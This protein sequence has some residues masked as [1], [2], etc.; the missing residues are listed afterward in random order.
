MPSGSVVEDLRRGGA[1][2]RE[3]SGAARLVA[4]GVPGWGAGALAGLAA[5]AAVP[6]AAPDRQQHA[7]S[8]FAGLPGSELG[9]AGSG[10]V[11]EVPVVGH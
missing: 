6:T 1:A 11:G 3:V 4:W 7:V 2:G 8:G 10:P 9:V 5:G